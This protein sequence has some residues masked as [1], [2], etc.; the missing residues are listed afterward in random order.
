MSTAQLVTHGD[1]SFTNMEGSKSQCGVI[2]LLTHEPW[3]FWQGEFQLGHKAYWTSNTIKL[4]VRS[5][6]AAEAYSVSE[7]C[8]GG[9]VA[10][11]GSSL[12]CGPLF[13]ALFH[14]P[15]EQWK[16][17]LCAHNVVA[18]PASFN[19]CQ[20]VKSHKGTGSDK[21][22]RIVTSMLRQVF[23]GAQG[24]TLVFATTATMLADALTKALV[25]CPSLLAVMNAR[26][27]VFVTFES[28]TSVVTTLPTPS[29]AVPT[30]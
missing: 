20:A 9:T 10:P 18:L 1:A 3:R 17:T 14:S 7:S 2:V 5:A 4:V 11:V 19:L 6:L 29:D 28:S 16:W 15:Y 12:K 23:C 13:R 30:L 24:A 22:L 27:Y 8:R 21:P 25:H 26:R